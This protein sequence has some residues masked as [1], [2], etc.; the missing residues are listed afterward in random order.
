MQESDS[1]GRNKNN[2]LLS[3]LD[4]RWFFRTEL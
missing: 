3:I 2:I 4:I 1:D